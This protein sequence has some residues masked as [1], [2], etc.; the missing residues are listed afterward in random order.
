MSEW[1][2]WAALFSSEETLRKFQG[3]VTAAA[4]WSSRDTA[5]VL[6]DLAQLKAAMDKEDQ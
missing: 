4:M 3:Q 2:E 6:E 1:D 5:E